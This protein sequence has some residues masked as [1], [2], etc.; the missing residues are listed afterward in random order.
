MD[1]LGFCEWLEHGGS[2]IYE[3][4][5]AGWAAQARY[6]ARLQA[7]QVQAQ[8]EAR[9]AAQGWQG[10]PCEPDTAWAYEA[11]DEAA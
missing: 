4:L 9:W 7:E 6:Q 1:Y 5:R 11:P 3:W 2:R 10:G 8:E